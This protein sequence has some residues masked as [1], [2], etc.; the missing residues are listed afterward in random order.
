[1]QKTKTRLKTSNSNFFTFLLLF[2]LDGKLGKFYNF[3]NYKIL[4][5]NQSI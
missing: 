3:P 4:S 2:S 5:I 1:M